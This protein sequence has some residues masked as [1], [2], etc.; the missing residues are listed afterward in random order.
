MRLHRLERAQRL[1]AP[2]EDVFPLFADALNLERITPPWLGFRVVA[3]GPIAMRAGACIEYR[4]RLHGF[5]ITWR[6]EIVLW[7]PPRRFVDVQR[8]GPYRLWHHTHSFEP[9]DGGTLMR[10][11]VR[12]A[13]PLGPL[14]A[15]THMAFVR[16]DLERIFDFREKEVARLVG[17]TRAPGC[18]RPM[19]SFT[20]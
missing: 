6:T 4:L 15:L 16:R 10:D 17:Y 20:K 1:P 12:Y 2:P 19:G 13:L 9:L 14:G 3:P 11:V 18:T 5:P 7:D 8:S